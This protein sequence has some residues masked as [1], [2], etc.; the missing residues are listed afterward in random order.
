MTKMST[1]I[2]AITVVKLA[3]STTAHLVSNQVELAWLSH[4]SVSNKVIE[5]SGYKI[6]A[7]FKE[8]I[9]NN[10]SIMVKPITSRNPQANSIL[11][12]IYSI[13]GNILRTFKA[14]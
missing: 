2:V 7:K 6:L 3:P 9:F 14:Q 13:I 1:I 10:Y 8:L 11:E 12:T 4:Y 5:D